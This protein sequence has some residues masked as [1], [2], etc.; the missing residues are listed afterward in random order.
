MFQIPASIYFNI[1]I[2]S[3]L[4]HHH[5]S[6]IRLSYLFFLAVT[7]AIPMCDPQTSV[8]VVSICSATPPDISD[9]RVCSFCPVSGKYL[10]VLGN[11]PSCCTCERTDNDNHIEYYFSKSEL[12]RNLPSSKLLT[13]R[14]TRVRPLATVNKHMNAKLRVASHCQAA[15]STLLRA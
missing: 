14:R 11:G 3:H 7:N 4:R 10:D 1:F 9:M 2:E 5:C 6:K 13:T 8:V 12:N 15:D